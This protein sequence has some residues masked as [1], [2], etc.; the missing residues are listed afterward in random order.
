M[1]QF[2]AAV[3]RVIEHL[4]G[5]PDLGGIRFVSGYPSYPR[6]SPVKQPIAA[7]ALQGV[8]LQS[9]GLGGYL[10]RTEQQE[11]SGNRVELSISIRIYS[12]LP[13]GGEGC[14]DVFSRICASLMLGGLGG[15][16]SVDGGALR[17]D[18]EA[19]AFRMECTVKLRLYW[20]M[21]SG[22]QIVERVTVKGVAT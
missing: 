18:G 14:A 7:V 9:G 10:G 3:S 20:G 19:S 22:G 5:D 1:S 11:L 15:V 17:Y 12:P 6:S 4:K 8:Q 21:D 16:L 2:D 13:L